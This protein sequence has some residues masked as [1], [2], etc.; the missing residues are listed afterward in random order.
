MRD[1]TKPDLRLRLE[2]PEDHAEVE[3]LTRLAF[4]NQ[5]FPGCDEHYL[6]HVLRD[7]PDFRADLDTVATLDDRIVG[8]IMYTRAR[9][10]SA[11]GEELSDVGCQRNISSGWS[12]AFRSGFV[13]T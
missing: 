5:H 1:A 4:W 2:R 11:Q 3:S 13:E 7:S 8:N 12:P 6:V 9:L 10:A